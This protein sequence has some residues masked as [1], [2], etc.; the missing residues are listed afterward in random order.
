MMRKLVRFFN[1]KNMKDIAFKAMEEYKEFIFEVDSVTTWL[2]RV[3]RNPN[4]V[5]LQ[6]YA[7]WSIP[8]RK[9]MPILEKKTLE[10]EGKWAY[11]RLDIDEVP[12]LATALQ[13][14]LVPTVFLINKGHSMNRIEGL[15]TE[16]S[17]NEFLDDV[18]LVAGLESDEMVFQGLLSAGKEFIQEKKYD[19]ALRSFS[20]A[21]KVKSFGEKHFV[22]CYEGMLKAAFNKGDTKLSQEYLEKIKTRK[23][24]LSTEG[25]KFFEDVEKSLN[26]NKKMSEE[27]IKKKTVVEEKIRQ[28][29]K[30]YEFMNELC[31][32]Y[33]ENGYHE[34]AIEIGLEIIDLEK[35]F[36]GYGQKA[37]VGIL[38][39]LGPSH[40]LT[41]PTRKRLQSLH[42]KYSV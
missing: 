32:L 35:S 9:L 40:V 14:K 12:D 6:A 13:I 27:F 16:E 1:E 11:G 7:N 18:K 24:E 37:V 2:D 3:L 28:N 8:C 17:I 15:P 25:A 34:E 33:Y 41:K 23:N 30:N 42:N 20:E 38:N 39:D 4:P 36:K 29:P 22:E 21:L 5:V 10:A 31:K 26:D 19:E